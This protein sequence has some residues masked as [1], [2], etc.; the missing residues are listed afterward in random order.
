M[1]HISQ[2]NK[3]QTVEGV[4]WVDLSFKQYLAYRLG[5]FDL[6]RGIIK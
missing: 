2:D 3:L 5:G 1:A 4:K 6:L